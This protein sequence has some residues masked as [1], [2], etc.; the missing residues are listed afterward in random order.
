VLS[1]LFQKLLAANKVLEMAFPSCQYQQRTRRAVLRGIS[2][3][4]LAAKIN[5]H[6]WVS[7]LDDGLKPIFSGA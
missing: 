4:L 5:L 2:T 7:N 6:L 3:K 1:G